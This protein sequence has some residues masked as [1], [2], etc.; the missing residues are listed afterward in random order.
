MNTNTHKSIGNK[1]TYRTVVAIATS[2]AMI[3]MASYRLRAATITVT[4]AADS[5]A[6]T[7]RAAVAAA[8]NGDKITF[9]LPTPA[10]ITLT[11]GELPV[12]NNITI[13]GPGPANLSISGNTNGRVFNI[14]TNRTV[15][16]FE[17]TIRDGRAG[18]S[19]DGGGIY[20]AGTLTLSN[21]DVCFNS[22]GDGTSA[23][24]PGNGGGIFNTGSLTVVS[25]TLRSNRGG[26]GSA[27]L[28]R[29]IFGGTLTPGGPGGRGGGIFNSGSLAIISSTL[30]D[31]KAG[32]GG[33]GGS[34]TTGETAASGGPGGAGG[35]ICN[36]GG[37]LTCTGCTLKGNKA[38]AGGGGGSGDFLGGGGGSG[39]GGGTGGGIFNGGTA[40][41]R[42]SLIALNAF[43]E[44]GL[45]GYGYSFYGS[46]G[47]SGSSPDVFGAF[48]SQGHNLIGANNGSTGLTNGTN[49]NIVGGTNNPANPRLG[50]LQ[51]NGG[52]TWT[53]SLLTG[54][55]AIDAGDDT[56]TGTDQRGFPRLSGAH[57]DIG[58]SEG[59]LQLYSR[60]EALLVGDGINN[61]IIAIEVRSG[62]AVGTFVQPS[63][64]TSYQ[65]FGPRG[66]LCVSN[67]LLVV[68]QNVDTPYNGEILSFD[69]N[70]GVFTGKFVP[71]FN[72]N[73]P[74]A[75]RG[76]MFGLNNVLYV[77]DVGGFDGVHLGR[78]ARYN[79]QGVFLGNAVTTGLP[80]PFFPM[81]LVT[82][83]DGFLYVSGVGDLSVGSIN[84][85]IFRF[86]FNA[87]TQNYQYLNTVVSSTAA[88]YYAPGLHSP[89]GIVF[90]PDGNIY[91][92]SFYGSFN[93]SQGTNVIDRDAIL[94]FNTSGQK[95]GSPIYLYGTNESRVFAQTMLFG[96]RGDLFVPIT[97]DSG[98]RRYSAGSNFQQFSVL[99]AS[100]ASP[101][102]PWYLTFRATDPRT[103]AYELPKLSVLAK[104]NQFDVSWPA[105]YVGWQLQAQTNTL[106]VGLSSN[107]LN[108]PQS[109]STN[110]LSLPRNPS[111]NSGAFYRLVAP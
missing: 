13:A 34:T 40:T 24:P 57:V 86:Q 47:V 60:G 82:G 107:W 51:D 62:A 54:S 89:E 88:N 31:N 20:N 8:A 1:F 58:A 42:N 77:A 35:G 38:G 93:N 68:N 28:S 70:T 71:S 19:S 16:L 97:S 48:T 45:P 14:A 78:I 100:G 63:A 7:L 29:T 73:A 74:Y 12:S 72:A 44:G 99:P 37:P 91:V 104:G 90:G 46:S 75:P 5:G 106:A 21:C 108:V 10:T 81:A 61:S 17:L 18:N 83:P 27:G 103:L 65:T 67:S 111:S 84:G 92:T 3:T 95:I 59:V 41:V 15:N 64:G 52:P 55:P 23:L 53:M 32:D 110:Y 43:G 36:A 50:A 26:F 79:S 76:M 80:V 39:G 49:G 22:A 102:Q 98:V 69:L 109:L 85:Y 94:V 9:S 33:Q 101:T 4:S 2:L 30:Y 66:L 56:L 96:P 6:G 87:G 11:N 25:C 105:K